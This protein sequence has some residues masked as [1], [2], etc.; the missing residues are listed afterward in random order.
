VAIAEIARGFMRTFPDMVV[1]MDHVSHDADGTKFQWTLTG[2]NTGPA[3][4]ENAFESAA[5]N[6]GNLI[7]P[8]SSRTRKANLTAEYERQRL[9]GLEKH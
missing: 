5:T 7:T 4:R 9:S 1:T 8:D 6:F 2:S 3:V